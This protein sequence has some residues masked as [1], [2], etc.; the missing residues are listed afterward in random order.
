MTGLGSQS[1]NQREGLSAKSSI[2]GN[3]EYVYSTG[4]ALN[5]SITGSSV[6]G[7]VNLT[8]VGGV[9]ISLGQTTKSASIPVTIASDQV[10]PVSQ[11]GTWNVGLN[12][13]SNA[14]GSITNTSFIATQST[15]ANL[16]ATVVG[17]GTFPVQVSS[18]TNPL[19]GAP[20]IGQAIIAV[21]STAVRLNGGTSQPLT[22]GIII[23]AP[24]GNVT[25]ISVGTAS[26]NNTADGTGNGYLLS[27][28]ASISFAV[29]NTNVI[30]IN[31][32]AGDYVSWAGS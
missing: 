1:P 20:L 18:L 8:K 24:A 15:A 14:I 3:N 19:V 22:N 12:A 13:G 29:T 11:S 6:T 4:H 10:V 2:T 30:Y 27:A 25:P 32:T 23:S 28:G 17:T 5:V 26:V 16:N 9:A 31:G 21:T 7:D